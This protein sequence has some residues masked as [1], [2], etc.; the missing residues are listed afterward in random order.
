MAVSLPSARDRGRVCAIAGA[1]DVWRVDLD[2]TA[3]D[4]FAQLLCAQERERAQRI[5][6][7]RRRA[8][9]THSRGVLRALLARYLDAD[10]RKLRF[11]ATVHGKPGLGSEPPETSR[12]GGPGS[13]SGE[14]LR[15]NL[16]HSREL[17]LLAV[18]AGREV[19]VDVECARKRRTAE[20]M[21]AWTLHEATGKCLGTGL[22]SP[23]PACDDAPEGMWAAAV[24]A[25]PRAF[26]AVA[27]A[28]AQACELSL[29]DWPG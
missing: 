29:L 10:P 18:T 11:V 7:A 5:V 20:F 25:G 4:G 8:L 14:S 22:V 28:G 6:D 9:W 21:R 3:D 16:S 26:A 2:R 12:D 1:V 13:G 27:V 24:D 19:G 15:F 17:M 23:P